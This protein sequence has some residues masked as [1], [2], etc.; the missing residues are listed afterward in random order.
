MKAASMNT[1]DN[2]PGDSTH[3]NPSTSKTTVKP[4]LKKPE[5][6]PTLEVRGGVV[7]GLKKPPR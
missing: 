2:K 6:P 3:P 1:N 7:Y 4:P 5:R